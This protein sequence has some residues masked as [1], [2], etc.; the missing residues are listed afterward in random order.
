M[1]RGKYDNQNHQSSQSALPW[2]GN[3]G[4]RMLTRL[5]RD[6]EQLRTTPL[7]PQRGKERVSA[8]EIFSSFGRAHADP[9]LHE[10]G[11]LLDMLQGGA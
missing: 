4:V 2:W 7:S 5:T 10:S 3:N 6:N 8:T 1:S 11:R 9:A